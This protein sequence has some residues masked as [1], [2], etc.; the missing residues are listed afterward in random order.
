MGRTMRFGED[1]R[2]Q[3]G[4]GGYPQGDSLDIPGNGRGAKSKVK[5]LR[6]VMTPAEGCKLLGKLRSDP[7]TSNVPIIVLTR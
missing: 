2:V 4:L 3:Y 7:L 6:L 5:V 1:L